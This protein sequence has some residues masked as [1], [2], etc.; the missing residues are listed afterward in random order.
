MDTASKKQ[1]I[2]L[3]FCLL[4][5]LAVSLYLFV[6]IVR[7]PFVGVDVSVN[8]NTV[9]VRDVDPYGR[10]AGQTI[11]KGDWIL[12][13]DGRSAAENPSVQKHRFLDHAE[14]VEYRHHDEVYRFHARRHPSL[15]G[16]FYYLAV[17][18]VFCMVSL[19]LGVYL[20][21]ADW[22]GRGESLF[23]LFVSVISPV[24]LA[25]SSGLRT[26]GL[27]GGLIVSLTMLYGLILFV[28]FLKNYFLFWKLSFVSTRFLI[29]LYVCATLVFVNEVF[30]PA[31]S[32]G[33]RFP[34]ELIFTSVI[35][36]ILFILSGRLYIRMKRNEYRQLLQVLMAGIV[37]AF[38][39]FVV[40][41]TLP[42][43]LFNYHLMEWPWTTPFLIAMPLTLFYLCR[44]DV[45]I[46]VSFLSGR[47][48]YY[49]AA[50][51]L[52]A[53]VIVPLF[54]A[55]M[56]DR[57]SY[58]RIDQIRLGLIVF[59]VLLL[60]LYI[61]DYVDYYLVKRLYPR[62]KDYQISLNRFLQWVKTEHD[63]SHVA[64]I[65]KRETE[66]G[67]PVEQ[68]SL[69]KCGGKMA[70]VTDDQAESADWAKEAEEMARDAGTFKETTKGFS[71]LLSDQGSEKLVL[72]G[73][74]KEPRRKLNP[75]ERTW[76][77]TFLNYAQIIIENRYRTEDFI[78]MMKKQGAE[79]GAVPV[80]LKKLMLKVSEQ[81]RRKLARMLHDRNMQDQLAIAR[82]IDGWEASWGDEGTRRLFRH[83]RERVLDSVY[84]LRQVIY[85]LHPEFI[86]QAGLVGSLRD[87]FKKVNLRADFR[88]S[89]S[90]EDDL[91][92]F[93]RDLEL[94]I[95]RVIQELLNNAMKH[96]KA[97]V[98]SLILKEDI[99]GYRLTYDDN[100]IGMDVT[101]LGQVLGTMGLPGMLSRVEGLGGRMNL[102]SRAG[103][104]MHVTITFPSNG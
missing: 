103:E 63:L 41:Y 25:V 81:E 69:L 90:I 24:L 35:F 59:L 85:E 21:V 26:S 33:A 71:V 31:Y 87:L 104:G 77:T 23:I 82:D 89:T 19:G 96:S 13:V 86:H 40:L 48:L 15:S 17:P 1:R 76:L 100:G 60:V 56:G 78:Q 88:L 46:D 66:I 36:A 102:R 11:D 99:G 49:G 61:K 64:G 91:T 12:S 47:L 101:R 44:S 97:D 37:L 79:S 28:H 27:H 70:F 75:D 67:L 14:T 5:S 53:S 52:C 98:V 2:I 34:L 51:A 54:F 29:S 80:T 3:F 74:W 10:L 83:I 50:S 62:R 42:L 30:F 38:F 58:G 9:V 95:Y 39:P 43:M 8:G 20:C 72:V 73:R 65:L 93:N 94:A 18:L 6:I 7:Y 4:L 32:L 16:V 45:F 68:A 84:I 22:R 92:I 55:L 57:I